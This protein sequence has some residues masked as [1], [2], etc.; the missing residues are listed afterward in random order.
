M[1]KKWLYPTIFSCLAFKII[2]VRNQ[3]YEIISESFCFETESCNNQANIIDKIVTNHDTG[4]LI[5][6]GKDIKQ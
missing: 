5:P 4:I 3:A 6:E 2:L 1:E